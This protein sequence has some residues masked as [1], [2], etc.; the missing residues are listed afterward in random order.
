[1]AQGLCYCLNPLW[2]SDAIWRHRSGSS[3][4][5]QVMDC[6]LTAPGHY[7]N[8]W[9]LDINL[10]LWYSTGTISLGMLKLP[11]TELLLKMKDFKSQTHLSGDNEKI[12]DDKICESAGKLTVPWDVILIMKFKLS[13]FFKISV[14]K[15][16]RELPLDDRRRNQLMISDHSYK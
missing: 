7:L 9:W 8:Q 13:I 1:M 4:L 10:V 5:S 6:C 11:I 3:R 16:F 14:Q 15:N 12:K 2:P